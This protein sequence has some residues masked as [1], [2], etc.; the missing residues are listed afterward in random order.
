MAKSSIESSYS[1]VV[2]ISL[3]KKDSSEARDVSQL[4][5]VR[6]YME[7]R[8]RILVHLDS[9]TSPS[10]STESYPLGSG[11][12]QFL[13]GTRGA[14]K[15]TFLS[16]INAALE[17]D[18]DVSG[19]MAFITPIDPSRIESSEI[20]LL[21]ILQ[22]LKKRVDD[23]LKSDRRDCDSDREEWRRSFKAVAGGLS[24]FA[25][26][27][28]PLDN[29]DPE[30]FLDWG[31]ERAGDSASL[32]TKLHCL[33]AIASRILG[34]RAIMLA[35][36]DADTNSTHA[37]TLLECIRKYLDTPRLMVLVTGDIELYSLLL[38]QH[39]AKTV[40]GR[41]DAAL[42]L[43]RQSVQNDRSVQYLRMIDHLEEQYLL[44]LFPIH[45]RLQLKSLWNVL[46]ETKC[47]ATYPGRDSGHDVKDLMC[48][49]VKSG[50]RVRVQA[51][52]EL[53]AE[54]IL[55]QPLRSSLQ[56]MA[57]CAPH[58]TDDARL[59]QALSE[60]LQGLALASLY[61]FSVDTDAIAGDDFSALAGAVFDLSLQDGDADVAMYLRPISAEPDIRSCFVAL[62]A[63]VSRFCA[64]NM[65][66]TLQYLLRGPGSI[67]LYARSHPYFNSSK[68]AMSSSFPA[69]FKSYIGIGTKADCFEWAC[70]A[71]AMLAMP[72]AQN[73][74]SRVILPG[75]I[76]LN[77]K[78]QGAQKSAQS[79]IARIV[80]DGEVNLFP[81]LAF[82]MVSVP[83]T[84]NMRTYF[85]IYSV[86]GVMQRILSADSDAS[87]RDILAQANSTIT[88]PAP[89]WA[90]HDVGVDYEGADKSA[91]KKNGAKKT[92][93][94]ARK[95]S[96]PASG[97]GEAEKFEA[98]L[99]EVLIWRADAKEIE[100]KIMPSAVF[101]GKVWARL[102]NSLQGAGNELR[103]G[104]DL[105]EITQVFALCV[106]NA[107]MVEE[108]A[109]HVLSG[110]VGSPLHIDRSN[111]KTS[112]KTF[113]KKF[114]GAGV[115]RGRLP[116]TAIIIT[117]PLILG[118]ISDEDSV[119]G[120]IC[121]LF[122]SDKKEIFVRRLLRSTAV[123]QQL[124]EIAISGE[125]RAR[126]IA[127]DKKMVDPL[128]KTA[129]SKTTRV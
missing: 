54:F 82:S 36:D 125:S 114:N 128:M 40:V 15:S 28:N 1:G 115:V 57:N 110:D 42:E 12:V 88:V 27:H 34:V 32:R 56:I 25:A 5:Q 20:I 78:A 8:T 19:G 55:R 70:R 85:S 86:L 59:M 109:Q 7:L 62:A 83:G 81:V 2:E 91:V 30:L 17:K 87:V 43:Q 52:V 37:I 6:R 53:Y 66:Q 39:F 98:L 16:S 38:R 73:P 120:A 112:L 100:S 51:D 117:C 119:A 64:G 76:G 97:A 33:F 68:A 96:A 118:L 122:P 9:L 129:S 124:K 94:A 127:D 50:L 84:T 63:G 99:A 31:L 121:P 29:L 105:A 101:M 46:A 10:S 79:V 44:K 113:I 102:Y 14:G 106:I 58:L 47:L 21:V 18:K 23:Y 69:I 4:V 41:S 65:G 89:S 126:K 74:K 48:L 61:K 13:D 107:F 26:D 92:A 111:P 49:M 72:Y 95:S 60:S 116:M 35:F 93:A 11:W 108:A 104:G 103:A 71:T 123:G 24:L 90:P 80:A 67:S 3:D 22:R 75:V 45:K 77:R